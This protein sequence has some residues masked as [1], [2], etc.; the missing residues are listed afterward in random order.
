M[1][2]T[3]KNPPGVRPASRGE[4]L[5][6]AAR[7]SALADAGKAAAASRV[8]ALPRKELP[9]VPYPAETLSEF[10]SRQK[11]VA[12]ELAT[13]ACPTATASDLEHLAG[14]PACLPACMSAC[15]FGCM[16]ICLVVC[17]DVFLTG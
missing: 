13:A 3:P 16:P 9:P 8:P 10:Q 15:L 12:R 11:D 6:A 7:A 5:A 1:K 14:Q 17:L 2:A 4:K